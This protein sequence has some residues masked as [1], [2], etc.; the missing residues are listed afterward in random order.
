MNYYYIIQ[1]DSSLPTT[2]E[3]Q[4]QLTDLFLPNLTAV[5]GSAIGAIAIAY[6]IKG[7]IR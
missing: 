2:Q 6:I 1:T 5:F 4:T 7:L 3:F